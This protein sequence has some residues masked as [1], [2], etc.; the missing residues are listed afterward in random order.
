MSDAAFTNAGV[1]DRGL[2]LEGSWH[3][4]QAQLLVFASTEA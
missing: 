4:A 2:T 3:F 1:V